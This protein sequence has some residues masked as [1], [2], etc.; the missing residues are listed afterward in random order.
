LKDIHGGDT[1]N[2]IIEYDFSVNINPFG[3]HE[4]V[5]KKMHE[6]VERIEE[7]PEYGAVSLQ[8]KVAELNNIAS[9][10]VV[11]TNGASEAFSL[12]CLNRKYEKG[13]VVYPN[14]SGYEYA[15]TGSNSEISRISDINEIFQKKNLQGTVVFLANPNNPD[16]KITPKNKLIEIIRYVSD[17]GGDIILDE[18]FLPL[19]LPI[20]MS[21]SDIFNTDEKILGSLYIVRSFTKTFAIPGVRLGY[22]IAGCVNSSQLRSLLPEWNTSGIAIEAGLEALELIGDL[23]EVRKYI[24]VEREFLSTKLDELGFDVYPSNANYILFNGPCGLKDKL[25]ERKILIRDCSNY[26]GLSDGS[27]RVAVKDH[28]ANVQLIQAIKSII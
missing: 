15:L 13:I 10:N 17:C 22:I 4:I 21:L 19:S 12:I 1:E 6:A 27:Y 26:Y 20:D 16:G 2:R 5:R 8:R 9:E 28:E 23:E 7:Y 24:S 11:I 25:L 3:C 14:F 18:C